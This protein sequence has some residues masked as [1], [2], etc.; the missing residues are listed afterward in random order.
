MRQKM[1]GARRV[2]KYTKHKLTISQAIDLH[3]IGN[4]AGK[5]VKANANLVVLAEKK[6]ID[7]V[8]NPTKK[9]GNMGKYYMTTE[10]VDTVTALRKEDAV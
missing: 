2:R 1:S 5:A 3:H 8:Q 4:M 7:V 10:G 6:L 9:N